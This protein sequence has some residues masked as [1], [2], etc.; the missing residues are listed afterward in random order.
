MSAVGGSESTTV[1]FDTFTLDV[2]ETNGT[3]IENVMTLNNTQPS[4][5]YLTFSKS[6]TSNL[7]GKTVR[8]RA[9]STNDITLHTNF[10]LDNLSFQATFCPP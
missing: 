4:A 10:F 2:L 7:A 8:L 5:T 9:T 1:V 3:L 6:L